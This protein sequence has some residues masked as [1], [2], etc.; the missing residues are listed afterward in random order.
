MLRDTLKPILHCA[1]GLRFGKVSEQNHKKNTRKTQLA[2]W[3]AILPNVLCNIETFSRISLAV[4]NFLTPGK[5]NY[6]SET[7]HSVIRPIC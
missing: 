1:L 6:A 2:R 7:T 3:L 4:G 5:I